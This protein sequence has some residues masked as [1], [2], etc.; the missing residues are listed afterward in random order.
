M[1]HFR[2][3]QN[4]NI[5]GEYINLERWDSLKADCFRISLLPRCAVDEWGLDAKKIS[6]LETD[7][8]MG[9]SHDPYNEYRNAAQEYERTLNNFLNQA[10]EVLVRNGLIG[11]ANKTDLK[12]IENELQ[13]AGLGE[14]KHRLTMTNLMD[15]C[16]SL[17]AFHQQ[18]EKVFSERSEYAEHL[19]GLAE[20]ELDEVPRFCLL[21]REFLDNPKIA[22]DAATRIMRLKRLKALNAQDALWPTE[23]A[24]RKG[25]ERSRRGWG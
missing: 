7:Q 9:A 13:E 14:G 15:F 19:Y 6:S 1:V 3:K 25:L 16:K 24:S 17:P 2:E 4:V 20:R 10:P 18:A 21:W 8:S 22:R 23:K 11:K 12:K 5:L